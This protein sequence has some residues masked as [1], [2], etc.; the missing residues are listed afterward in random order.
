MG[1]TVQAQTVEQ[2]A[3]LM[4]SPEIRYVS[5]VQ[6]AANREPFRIV[7]N[8]IGGADM[9]GSVVQRIIAPEGTDVKAI[10][11]AEGIDFAEQMSVEVKSSHNGF[12]IYTQTGIEK[13]ETGDNAFKLHKIGKSDKP[14]LIVTG[15]LKQ[16]FQNNAEVSALKAD[17]LSSLSDAVIDVNVEQGYYGMYISMTTAMD[18]L[19]TEVWNLSRGIFAIG[20]AKGMDNKTRLKSIYG[21]V[22]GFKNFVG[23]LLTLVDEQNATKTENTGDSEIIFTKIKAMLDGVENATKQEDTDMKPEEMQAAITQAVAAGMAQAQKSETTVEKSETEKKMDILLAK[24]EAIEAEKAEREAAEKAEQAAKAEAERV[25]VE[26]LQ[27]QLETIKA[28]K[29]TLE[30]KIQALESDPETTRQ[31]DTPQSA[32]KKE[33]VAPITSSG[34]AVKAEHSC[35]NDLFTVKK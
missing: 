17:G 14:L 25:T 18:A 26:D 4:A 1:L 24:L 7:K 28:E 10:L 11:L 21:M 9:G 6:H 20:S 30:A 5:L 8:D 15:K 19:D 2:E 22:D 33:Q 34:I 23:S 35:F 29:E 27:K 32:T 16:E 13:F 3:S 12:D 31:T